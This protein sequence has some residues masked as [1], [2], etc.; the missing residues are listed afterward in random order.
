MPRL[1]GTGPMGQGPLTGR[2][3][4]RCA[5]QQPVAG[6]FGRGRG[7]GLGLGLGLG[8]GM[9]RS[10]RWFA[11]AVPTAQ[12]DD[13]ALLEQQ[14]ELLERQLAAVRQRLDQAKKPEG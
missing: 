2:G 6:W 1:D 3:L 8:W 9:R 12:T 4:G 10:G 5:G 7:L 14:A 11:P 13:T